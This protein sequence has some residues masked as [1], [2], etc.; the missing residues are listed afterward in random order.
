[1]TTLNVSQ[2]RINFPP[3][4]DET[5]YPDSLLNT[6]YTIGKCYME[7]SSCVANDPDCLE[8]MF[9]LMLAH[10]LYI[11]DEVN[12]GNN[13]GVVTTASEGDVSVTLAQPPV[14][15]EFHYWYNSSPY[16]RQLIVLLE[17]NAIGGTFVGGLPERKGFRKFAGGF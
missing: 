8:Y 4:A 13:I 1:M 11:R 16:G 10:L 2:F 9:E 14:R 6:Q 15:D 3:Y 17:A 12:S 7:D 5:T